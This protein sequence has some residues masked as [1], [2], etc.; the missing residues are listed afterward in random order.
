MIFIKLLFYRRTYNSVLLT[1]SF[2]YK[3]QLTKIISEI[4]V[5]GKIFYMLYVKHV[6]I[7]LFFSNVKI[8]F[9]KLPLAFILN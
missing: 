6:C 5:V 3:K 7:Q 9:T 2:R 1:K 4:H 8:E